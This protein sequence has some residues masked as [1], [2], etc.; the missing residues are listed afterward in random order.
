M[1]SSLLLLFRAQ[2]GAKDRLCEA[3]AA[4]VA[5]DISHGAEIELSAGMSQGDGFL[6]G[7]AHGELLGER[8]RFD[9]YVLARSET[10]IFGDLAT[11]LEP[12]AN[13]LRP[14][15]DADRSAVLAGIERSVIPGEGAGLM[16]FAFR[17]RPS[18]TQAECQTYWHDHH[19]AIV[20]SSG[21]GGYRQLHV[22]SAASADIA[23]RF[24]FGVADYDGAVLKRHAG[25]DALHTMFGN[26]RVRTE[27]LPD[28]C[29][30][31]DHAH[32][33][34]VAFSTTPPVQAYR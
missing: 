7:T 22:D 29:V 12:I 20:R 28:E 24:G 18:M 32:S 23:H 1:N 19:G 10:R 2:H 26:P 4:F 6:D 30:F 31:I 14:H 16:I 27:A 21:S 8:N 3:L 33:G 5:N 13:A 25:V 17:R 9:A 15:I 11:R 34:M